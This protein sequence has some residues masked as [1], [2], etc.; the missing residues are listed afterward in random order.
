MEL[1]WSLGAFSE[2]V[3]SYVGST[4]RHPVSWVAGA[5]SSCSWPILLWPLVS[6]TIAILVKYPIVRLHRTLDLMMAVVLGNLQEA[7][8][9]LRRFRTVHTLIRG[10]LQKSSGC[11]AKGTNYAADDPVLKL[12]VLATLVDTSVITY[13]RFNRTLTSREKCL[14]YK[15]ARLLGELMGIPIEML[16]KRIEDFNYFVK[17]TL[18]GQTLAVTDITHRLARQVLRPNVSGVLRAFMPL[19]RFTTTGLL[20]ERLREAYGFE[21]SPAQQATLDGMSWVIRLVRP[22]LPSSICL[23]PQAGGGELVRLVIQTTR[24]GRNQRLHRHKQN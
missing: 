13:E 2:H 1:S 7:Q 11:F 8:E 6:L 14:F 17:A 24:L 16:P 19:I 5:L 10:Q 3:A 12:W 21:W 15:D 9:A 20:P 18:E 22:I 23:M 4:A